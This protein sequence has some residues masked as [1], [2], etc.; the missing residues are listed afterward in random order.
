MTPPTVE[1]TMATKI[2]G[3]KAKHAI[4]T[5]NCRT[6]ERGTEGPP[7]MQAFDEAVRRLREEYEQIV[8]VRHDAWNGHLV[9]TVEHPTDSEG[10]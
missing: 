9:F 5:P 3:I 2:P 8:R 4:I 6:I 7:A 1:K 10:G